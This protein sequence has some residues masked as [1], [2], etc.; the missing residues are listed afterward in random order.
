MYRRHELKTWPEHF[1]AVWDGRK[2]SEIR[3]NDRDFQVMDILVLKEWD[4]K[5][6]TYSGRQVLADIHH[7]QGGL[8][9]QD[10]YVMLSI[11]QIRTRVNI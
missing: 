3:L 9:L 1:Q 5:T 6:N 10:G 4:P 2:N 11:P 8:G 7:I